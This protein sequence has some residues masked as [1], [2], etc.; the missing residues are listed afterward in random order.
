MAGRDPSGYIVTVSGGWDST[1]ALLMALNEA[2]F[3]GPVTGMFVNYN[4]PYFVQE[5]TKACA[6][7]RQPIIANHPQ[8]QGLIS[9][10]ANLQ[11]DPEVTW[12]PYRNLVIASMGLH[13]ALARNCR[14]VVVGSKSLRYRPHDPSSYLDSSLPF[15]D[16]LETL[17]GSI[18]EEMHLP[19]P[20]I[21]MPIVGWSKTQVLRYLIERG[22]DARA[23]WNCYRTDGQPEPCGECAHCLES[24]PLLEAIA[25][26]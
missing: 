26:V 13:F 10:D 25:R 23:L 2:P 5:W 19:S 9:V 18:T 15:Y 17:A 12:V 6:L 16:R 22:I 7:V 24:L 1:A 8:W 3:S 20:Q 11:I 14:A 4:Q 21:W